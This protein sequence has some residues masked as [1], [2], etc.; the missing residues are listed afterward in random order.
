MKRKILE[1]QNVIKRLNK[2]PLFENLK[3]EDIKDIIKLCKHKRYKKGQI[4]IN[5]N[6]VGD[7]LFIVFKGVIEIQKTTLQK[8]SYT[9]VE[10]NA[11]QTP[12]YVGELA[13]IDNDKRSAT[14]LAKTDCECLI[15]KRSNF[16][17]YGNKNPE[18]GL[19]LTR[20]I[21]LNLAKILRRTNE[22]VII[23]F[24]ALVE[25]IGGENISA[26]EV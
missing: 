11:N 21:A 15:L 14:V 2:L 18:I 9:V 13:M 25:E 16:I 5:E 22:E 10:L 8:E 24:S 1:D 20:A 12:I 3:I 23:L 6:D 19:K 7:E 4:L 17:E 26:E